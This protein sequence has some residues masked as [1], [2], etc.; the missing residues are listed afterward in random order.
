MGRA[1]APPKTLKPIDRV[2]T[3]EKN[4]LHLSCVLPLMCKGNHPFEFAKIERITARSFAP[5][6]SKCAVKFSP[7]QHINICYRCDPAEINCT[8]CT[9]TL[10]EVE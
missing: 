3:N 9:L 6:C 8:Y 7:G 2:A 10:Q 4:G 5:E 1:S